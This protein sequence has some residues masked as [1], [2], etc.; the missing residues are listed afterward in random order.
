MDKLADVCLL[1]MSLLQASPAELARYSKMLQPVK[2][3]GR[4]PREPVEPDPPREPV[5]ECVLVLECAAPREDA[6]DARAVKRAKKTKAERAKRA[7]QF[8]KLRREI[9]RGEVVME[10]F[11]TVKEPPDLAATP[12]LP[13]G[14]RAKAYFHGLLDRNTG[15][16]RYFLDGEIRKP[17][18]SETLEGLLGM[19]PPVFLQDTVPLTTTRLAASASL[20]KHKYLDRQGRARTVGLVGRSF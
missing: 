8:K 20:W 17:L 12:P 4:P 14:F 11:S 6:V 2:K 5:V 15:N 19:P 10:L 16:V 18:A 7:S 13:G 3:R 9:S 1:E